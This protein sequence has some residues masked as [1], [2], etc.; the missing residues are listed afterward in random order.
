[1]DAGESMVDPPVADT[2]MWLSHHWPHDYD[3]CALVAGRHVCRRCLVLYPLAL[4]TGIAVSVGSWWPSGLDPWI[5]WLAPLP[6]V[7]EFAADNLGLIGYSPIRQMVLS[8]GGAVAAGVGYTRYLQDTTDGLVWAVLLT[9]SLVCLAAAVA[10][11]VRRR[12]A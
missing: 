4:V 6:G 8:A 5:L 2:P 3:R 9:Y 10:G 1:M 12:N 11:A 7:I